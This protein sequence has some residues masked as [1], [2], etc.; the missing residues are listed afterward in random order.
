MESSAE[1]PIQPER[2]VR[3]GVE[4]YKVDDANVSLNWL[5]TSPILKAGEVLD[6]T[7]AVIFL[8]AWTFEP[9]LPVIAGIGDKLADG[10]LQNT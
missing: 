3:K 5:E 9:E 8:L 2:A 7:K 6:P 1:V 4:N 10:T